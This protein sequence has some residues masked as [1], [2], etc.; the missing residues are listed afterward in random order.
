MCHSWNTIDFLC[1]TAADDLGQ[2]PLPISERICSILTNTSLILTNPYADFSM[3]SFFM[4]NRVFH[5][6]LFIAPIFIYSVHYNYYMYFFQRNERN[7]RNV[8]FSNSR[9]LFDLYADNTLF[10]IF[11]FVLLLEIFC[12]WQNPLT[13]HRSAQDFI[14][15]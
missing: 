7:E 4:P 6:I 11:R 9:I 1:S 14:G 5:D 10:F 12:S 13:A 8:F 3:P 15:R 2:D